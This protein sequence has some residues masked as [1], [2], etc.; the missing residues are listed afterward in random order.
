MRYLTLTVNEKK[1]QD[2]NVIIEPCFSND[3]IIEIFR[4]VHPEWKIVNIK[5]SS[6]KIR[7]KLAS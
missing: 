6:K 7:K 5:E 2:K 4:E 3:R 1:K